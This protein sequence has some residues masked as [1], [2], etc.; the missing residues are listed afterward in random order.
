MKKYKAIPNG[1]HRVLFMGYLT[2]NT[3]E[4]RSDEVGDMLN[5][6]QLDIVVEEARDNV[7]WGVCVEDLYWNEKFNCIEIE[8]G[9]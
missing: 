7:G 3:L 9:T 8:M 4:I 5:T 6:D 1:K 2:K